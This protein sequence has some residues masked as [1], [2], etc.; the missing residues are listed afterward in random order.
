LNLTYNTETP[1]FG[2]GILQDIIGHAGLNEVMT[3]MIKMVLSWTVQTCQN[4]FLRPDKGSWN[5]GGY[6]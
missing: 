4:S 1:L 5:F 6:A 3:E 2:N